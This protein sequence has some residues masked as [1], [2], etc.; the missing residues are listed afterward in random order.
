MGFQVTNLR[1]YASNDGLYWIG[2]RELRPGSGWSVT[3]PVLGPVAEEGLR[4]RYVR[5]DGSSANAPDE[6]EV[7]SVTIV[8]VGYSQADAG[9]KIARDSLTFLISVRNNPTGN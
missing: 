2:L 9:S 7:I 4:F 6:V 5:A 8:G 3:Q 1:L